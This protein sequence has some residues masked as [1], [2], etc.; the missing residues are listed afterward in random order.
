MIRTPIRRSCPVPSCGLGKLDVASGGEDE[1]RED[2]PFQQIA[3]LVDGLLPGAGGK[4]VRDLGKFRNVGELRNIGMLLRR[5]DDGVRE[6]PDATL[7]LL[8][9]ELA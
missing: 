4:G 7:V 9:V 3:I 8:T 2:R 6:G 1:V 5:I